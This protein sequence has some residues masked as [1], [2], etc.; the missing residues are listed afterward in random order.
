[1][2]KVREVY[3]EKVVLE[4]DA[5]EVL[6][7]GGALLNYHRDQQNADTPFG[8]RLQDLRREIE[9]AGD[10]MWAAQARARGLVVEGD[11]PVEEG[12]F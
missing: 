7:I 6:N 1:M 2:S 9:A 5:T 3:P 11:D 8:C 12:P 10:L 4:L